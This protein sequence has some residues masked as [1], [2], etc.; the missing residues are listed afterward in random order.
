[1][2]FSVDSFAFRELQKHKHEF[3]ADSDHAICKTLNRTIPVVQLTQLQKVS[4]EKF[5]GTGV[6][7]SLQE[8]QVL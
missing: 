7:K 4:T 3:Y 6:L 2:H 8:C 5:W 1:M